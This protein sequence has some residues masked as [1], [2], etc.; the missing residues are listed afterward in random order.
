MA[1]DFD[2]DMR[3][4]LRETFLEE[5]FAL[6]DELEAAL[7]VL[8]RNA[9][10]EGCLNAAFRAA[11]TIKG[12]AA[13]VGCHEVAA[14]T[15]QLEN[16]LDALRSRRCAL[17]SSIATILLEG[18]DLL[19]SHLVAIRD[20]S[21]PPVVGDWVT[22]MSHRFPSLEERRR[23]S[24]SASAAVPVDPALL[25]G[26]SADQ[27]DTLRGQL[28]SGANPYCVRFSL[29]EDAFAR[30]LDPLVLLHALADEGAVVRT[31]PLL[32]RLPDLHTL[33]PTRCYLGFC[34]LVVSNGSESDLRS[35]FEF[36]PEGSTVELTLLDS[37]HLAGLLAQSGGGQGEDAD[38]RGRWKLLGEV[39]VEE[40]LATPSD[41]ERALAKQQAL[42]RAGSGEEGRTLRV[43]QERLDSLMNLVGEIVTAYN[44][45][46]HLQRLVDSEYRLPDL[47]RRLK[48][49]AGVLG[50]TAGQLHHEV[51]ALRMVPLRTL[52]QRL[53]RVIRDVA[54]RQGK[55]VALRVS[56]EETE[57]DKTV[58]DALVDPLTHLVRNAV[59][60]G[61]EPPPDRVRAN[62]PE[63]G[64]VSIDARREGRSVV[65][66][67]R[68]DGRGIDPDRVRR[69]AVARGMV[70]ER[71]AARLSEA[72]T[73]DLI[74][75]AG[76]STA[77][78]VSDISGRGVG[79][80]VVRSNVTRMGGSITVTSRIGKGTIFRLVVPLTVSL[81]RAM[82][83]RGGGVTFALPLECVRETAVLPPSQRSSVLRRSVATIR[84]Q[85]VGIV[86]LA[87]L[88]GLGGP[89]SER[90]ADAEGWS[91]IVVEAG[92]EQVGLLVEALDQPQ[93]I[94]VKPLDGYLSA[95]GALAG[96]AIMGDG[97]IA[98]VMEPAALVRLALARGPHEEMGMGSKTWEG[99]HVRSK[100]AR[101]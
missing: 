23:N 61:I 28:A 18:V 8:E 85:L 71:S 55:R 12:S 81:F 100:G 57:V 7:L 45:L 47:A 90:N 20:G 9:D 27:L 51:L 46:E 63:E 44:S 80:D 53:P 74:F 14:F 89:T 93:E 33:D 98:L 95:E 78:E 42:A 3:S 4:R 30:G 38:V 31:V 101:G 48:G 11:H 66:E 24:T 99:S 91:V 52:F 84:G 83:I 5:A 76:L 26:L 56:G 64:T 69:A 1:A 54:A 77:A 88:M 15:H 25:E 32:E 16:T 65:I 92:G 29:P 6:A 21:A 94:M 70:D 10:D 75:A 13:G 50:R 73:L 19:R 34:S 82:V 35:A 40:K 41:I 17:D 58:A 49:A 67:V 87:E 62:K 36:C 72:E 39:L 22:R 60:H 2:P 97:R 43:K 79:M 96:A 59:D 68:D 37:Q 86:S